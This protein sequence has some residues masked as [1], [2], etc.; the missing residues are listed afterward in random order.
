M[1]TRTQRKPGYQYQME[2]VFRARRNG[3]SKGTVGSHIIRNNVIYDCG[4]NGIVGHMGCVFSTIENN[5]IYNIAVKHEYFGYEIA[6]IKLHAAIDVNIIHNNIHN[7]TLGTWLDWQAQ[8]VRVSRNLYYENDRDLMIEVTH[9][10]YKVDNNIF[11]SDYNFDNVAQGGAYIHNLCCGTMRRVACLD[12]STPYH[13]PHSTEVAGCTIVMSGDD[14]L[15]QN[16]F[17][18]G[19]PEFTEESR[20]GTDGYNEHP[21]SWEEY[22]EKIA[23]LGNEDHEKFKL[24]PQAVYING[25]AYLNGTGAYDKEKNNYLTDADPKIRIAEE[26]DGTYLEID[27]EEGVLNIP[28]EIISTEML[29]MPRITEAPFDDSDGNS[30][31]FNEDYFGNQRGSK[32]VSGPVE[33]LRAGHNRI[34]VW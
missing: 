15:Y 19:A 18:G 20:T 16:I 8:G 11:A 30:I 31:V 10:P 7:S 4:Q 32:P 24:V 1:C 14:R 22:V 26:A 5:H 29:G 6:G 9:G 25:N 17:V 28:T 12:R 21:S 2:A 33:N 3:W 34:R 13:F 27:V 23:A